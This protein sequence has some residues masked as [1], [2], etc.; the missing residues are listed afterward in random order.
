M[1]KLGR[2]R[3]GYTLVNTLALMVAV[4]S[5]MSFSIVLIRR[6]YTT[7]QEALSHLNTTQ[8]LRQVCERFR[9]D[10][11]ECDSAVVVDGRF[12]LTR[13]NSRIVFS[14]ESTELKRTVL[15]GGEELSTETWQLPNPAVSTWSI[16]TSGPLDLVT[17][18]LKFQGDGVSR[19][20]QPIQWLARVAVFESLASSKEGAAE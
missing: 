12:Q 9:S 15:V 20:M 11:H 6:A 4:G 5:L 2:A 7:H 16:E 14:N 1:S 19:Q 10:A 17:W 3:A 13:G 18:D 8:S